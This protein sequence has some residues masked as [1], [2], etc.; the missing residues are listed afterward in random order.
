[1][2]NKGAII[3][4]T[5][6]LAGA[7]LYQLSFSYFTR[8]VESKAESFGQEKLDSVLQGMPDLSLAETDSIGEFYTNRFIKDH[9]NEQV[10]PGLG[11]TYQQCKEKGMNLGLDLAGGMSVVLEVSIP[12]LVQN[13]SGNS[14]NEAFISTMRKARERMDISKDD[15]ITLFEQTWTDDYNNLELW[16]IFHN[17][18]NKEKFPQ[19]I[20]NDEVISILREEAQVAIENTEKIIRTRIDKFGV[21]Q[22]TIQKQEYSGRILIELPGVKDKDRIRKQLKSTANLEF[23][24]T[25]EGRDILPALQVA[26]QALSAKYFPDAFDADSNAVSGDDLD[27][28]LD[29]STTDVD[30]DE[31]VNADSAETNLE[32]LLAGDDTSANGLES[33]IQFDRE[34]FRKQ[35]PLFNVLQPAVTREGQFLP[36]PVVGYAFVSDTAEV[37]RLLKDEVAAAAIPSDIKLLWSA[38]SRPAEEKNILDLYAIAVSNRERKAD[39]DG[40]VIVEARQDYDPTGRVEVSMQMNSEGAK[41]WK[42]LTEDH[43][44]EAIAIVLDDYVYSAPNV[45]SEIPSGRSSISM[46][47]GSSTEQLSEAKDLAN[48]LKAGALPARANIVEESIVGPSLGQQKHQRWVD[49]LCNCPGRDPILY[50]VLLQGCRSGF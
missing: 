39:L 28:L 43:I 23:W 46:G 45:I 34:T 41:I 42:K 14:R 5:L 48:L 47:A 50:G 22:P 4:F 19:N 10:Y 37:N 35:N 15:F 25:R 40:S 3:L 33:E 13:L 12:E 21:A 17:R 29:G 26:N 20:S 49:V 24:V 18:D 31:P 44:G 7:S 6:L 27:G 30:S 32:D 16:K 8:Q 36:G 38:K 9:A 1:M 2:Q 11:F